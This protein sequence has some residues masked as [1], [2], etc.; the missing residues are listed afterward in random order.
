MISIVIIAS[1]S[2][3]TIKECL[4]SSIKFD[5]VILYLNNSNDNTKQIALTFSNVKVVDG[6]FDGFGTTKN[7]ALTYTK[8]EWVFVL[9]SDEK[10][11]Q[12]LVDE[13]L[14]LNLDINSC[15]K[16]NRKNL[17]LGEEVKYSGWNPDWIVRLFNKNKTKFNQ[18]EVHEK[19]ITK[20]L[21][22]KKLNYRISHYAINDVRDFL[23]KTYSYSNLKRKKN[24]TYHPFII[25]TK[26]CFSF[27]KTYFLKLGF[28]DGYK[29]LVISIGNFNGVFFKYMVSY[30]KGKK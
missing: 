18:V 12:N 11:E 1:N 10:F 9:D 7:R 28:L 19:V 17:F 14:N 6:Y 25:F 20:N 22:I 15:Y 2:Q 16:V 21:S 4:E 24:K 27:F 29:G 30:A 3:D 23:L 13:L 8:N 26:A 5:E